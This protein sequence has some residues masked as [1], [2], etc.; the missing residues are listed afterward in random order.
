MSTDSCAFGKPANFSATSKQLV[1]VDPSDKAYAKVEELFQKGWKHREKEKPV[2]HTLYEV[3]CS[4]RSLDSYAEHKFQY[5]KR[6]NEQLLFHGTSQACSFGMSPSNMALCHIP[7]C[8]LCSI[9]WNS[10]DVQKCGTRHHFQRFG[11]GI[12]VTSCSSKADDYFLGNPSIS[13]SRVLLVNRV[14]VGKAAKYRF[15]ATT[16]IKP[17]RGYNSVIGIPGGDL[18]YEETVVYH[19]DAI[20]P[21]YVVIYGKA[22]TVIPSMEA[23]PATV[24]EGLSCIQNT[25]TSQS[26]ESP[27]LLKNCDIETV[28]KTGEKASKLMKKSSSEDPLLP[29][30]HDIETVKKMGKK[31]SKLMKKPVHHISTTTVIPHME[32][33]SQSSESQSLPRNCD[34]QTEKKMGKKLKKKSVLYV[35]ATT[36]SDVQMA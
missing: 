24:M 25:M 23:M 20:R 32:A 21:A 26:S 34:I 14:I 18:S 4:Q 7:S 19:N 5:R 36:Q 1:C 2:I 8:S 17:P 12:Y 27:S 28:K 3:I 13:H 30:D 6:A 29:R 10:F 15:N 11:R 16:L 22:P 9:V 35:P 31:A 33:M